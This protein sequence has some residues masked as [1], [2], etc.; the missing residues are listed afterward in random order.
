MPGK[1]ILRSQICLAVK[2]RKEKKLQIIREKK[3][4]DRTDTKRKFNGYSFI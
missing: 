4:E 1:N 3:E 2:R